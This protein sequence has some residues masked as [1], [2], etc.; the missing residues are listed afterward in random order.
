MY[1]DGGSCD[2]DDGCCDAAC[3][4]CT[5][6]NFSYPWR[7]NFCE[8]RRGAGGGTPL[9]PNDANRRHHQGQDIRAATCADAQHWVVAAAGGEVIHLP[10]AGEQWLDIEVAEGVVDSYLHMTNIQVED[11][12]R[13]NPGQLLGQVSN[14]TFTTR[15]LH[16]ERRMAASG[17]TFTPV[18]PYI[19]LLDA[20]RK[21][22]GRIAPGARVKATA[23]IQVY[24]SPVG[25]VIGSKASG[26]MGTVLGNTQEASQDGYCWIWKQIEWDGGLIGYS[27]DNYLVAV[28]PNNLV[29]VG[30]DGL[31]IP[32]GSE[33]NAG[34]VTIRGLVSSPDAR[35]VALE[36]ELRP[37]DQSFTGSKTHESGLQASGTTA[38]ICASG[39]S[40]DDY[41]W[42]ARV[43]DSAGNLTPWRSYGGNADSATDFSVQAAVCAVCSA[44]SSGASSIRV[45]SDTLCSVPV[46]VEL[47]AS[48]STGPAPLNDVSLTATVGG[49]ATGTINYTFYCNR[50]DDGTNITP[51]YAAKYNDTPANPKTAPGICDYTAAGTY[52][53][54][55]IAERGSSADE[56]R[57]TITVTTSGL[58]VPTVTTLA[59]TSVTQTSAT[60]NASVHPQNSLTTFWFDYGPNTGVG[61]TTVTRT[62]AAATSPSAVSITQDGLSCGQQYF[63]R[64]RASNAGGSAT[65]GNLISFATDACGSGGSDNV[66]LVV[67]PSFEAGDGGWWVADEDFYIDDRFTNERTGRFYAYL[68]NSD[69]SRGN[70][71]SG[72]VISPYITIPANATDADLRFWYSITSDETTTST[73]FDKVEVYLVRP[74]D[75]LN[76]ITTISNLDENGTSYDLESRDLS[77]S[78]YG[79]TVQIFFAGFTDGSLP[80]VFRIDDVT[81]DVDVPSGS[82]PTVTTDPAD[83]VTASSARLKMTV[84]PNSASTTVWFDLEAGDSTPNDD[85]EHISIGAGSQSESVSIS[86]FDLQCATLYYFQAEASNS[87]GS[88]SG[89]VRSF[90]TA[91]CTGGSPNADT[92]P[93]ENITQTSAV[94]TAD[95]DPNGL[96]TQAWFA[97]G[98]TPDLGQET[99][100][101]SVGSGTGNVDF[102]QTV[103]GLS[104]GTTYYFENHASNSAGHD[105]GVTLEF[106]TDSCSGPLP[107]ITVT[108][109]DD[110]A[111]E[112]GLSTGR[113]RV[114][115]T[116]STS[117]ALGFSHSVSG[118]ATNG[119]DY[120]DLGAP[121]VIPAA[122]ASID[123]I[124]QPK[125][126]SQEEPSET[127]VFT[128]N[129]QS[130]YA[131]GTPSSATVTITSD[132]G[133][134]SITN[135]TS[136]PGGDTWAKSTQ[137]LITWEASPGC[138]DF[139]L[140]LRNSGFF[141]GWIQTSVVETQLLWTP[142]Q[143][144]VPGPDFTIQVV[145]IDTSGYPH[146]GSSGTFTL[147]NLSVLPSVV[148]EDDFEGNLMSWLGGGWPTQNLISHSPTHSRTDSPGSYENG[149]NT[150]LFTPLIDV[151]GRTSLS[152]TFWH[153]FALAEFD[154]V[155][156][157]A[158][159]DE[160]AWTHLRGFSGTQLDWRPVTLNLSQFIGTVPIQMAFQLL[161]DGAL[162]AD[163]WY[164]DD[165]RLYE[166]RPTDF[167]TVT[168]CR[169]ADTRATS[170][171]LNSGVAQTFAVGGVC[172]VPVTA[173]AVSINATAVGGGSAGHII[174]FPADQAVPPTSTINFQAGQIRANN[175][176]LG[177]SADGRLAALAGLSGGS[178]HLILDVNGYF[179]ELH[180]MVGVWEGTIATYASVLY[181]EKGQSGF[182][183]RVSMEGANEPIEDLTVTLV[184]E[185]EFRAIRPLDNNAELRL[186][187]V[188]SGPQKC[189]NGEYIELGTSRPISLCKGS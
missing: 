174:I 26:S 86:V 126:D 96:S 82:A 59:A 69:G 113:F 19:A 117:G 78:F 184:S 60:F 66:Q 94:L 89:S 159:R 132:D 181:I 97:W 137:R 160:G 122:S 21:I 100:H 46:L 27:K 170:S 37:V 140:I 175:A 177:L 187:L 57:I 31:I 92:D 131:V 182:T 77:S 18:S 112:A 156:V 28:A 9:C 44:S 88:D 123:V 107:V 179:D 99:S 173:K 105:D 133:L 101:L 51:G 6:A 5:T 4:Q 138:Q 183:A 165:V 56:D 55:V 168:P 121:L 106:T 144:L 93:A 85:T 32:V 178:V 185:T 153:R 3:N 14:Q 71:L 23:A 148:F 176:V 129:P 98:G 38:S 2:L 188:Q 169:L 76:L 114:T 75:Q 33:T 124:V 161:S 103:S 172:G 90:T 52:T 79:D 145:S 95:V 22:I 146:G 162:T 109:I 10:Q 108:A 154:N 17:H 39:L 102:S 50:S 58:P 150:S 30:H 48:P 64:S 8:W 135:V 34:A 91:A 115:R 186:V 41:H 72:G 189:L 53:A 171:P 80:S 49:G 47:E 65:P 147:V 119:V 157:W 40:N 110:L 45:V 149:V 1:S 116:G 11:G 164:I 180:P 136:T 139:G 151:S 141:I 54:K 15:H 143:W 42:R 7:D 83:Q 111:S 134:C 67:D 24:S 167:Y 20:Y 16:F 74:P 70:N 163:G 104:C 13:V 63:Y 130:S 35:S 120:E 62:L 127:V 36:V 128:I 12:E 29:Q 43:R 166:P 118:T 81:L 142:P 87:F 84:D 152:L 68:S 125:Q 25:S 155:N 61:L 73:V 158:R